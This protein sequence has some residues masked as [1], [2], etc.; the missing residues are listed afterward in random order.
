MGSGHLR[1]ETGALV[2]RIVV[3]SGRAVGVEWEQGGVARTATATAEV[4]LS[5]GAVN[6][7]QVLML[8]GIG[9]A[10]HLK[11]HGIAVAVDLPGVGENLQDHLAV[12]VVWRTTGTTSLHDH[13]TLGSLVRWQVLRS[14]PLTS[15]VAEAC[16]FVRSA[17]HLPAP[18]LQ[19]HVAPAAFVDNG[20]GEPPGPGFTVAP[21]LVAPA[22]SG[23]L[24]LRS[25]HPGWRPEIDAGYLT[26]DADLEALVVGTRLAREM[27]QDGPLQRWLDRELMPGRSTTSPDGLR[28]HV[29]ATSQTLYHPVGTCAMGVG[30]GSVVDL[31]CRVRG[32]DG[33]RVVDA[34]I[35][36]RV[37]RGNTNAPTIALAEKAAELILAG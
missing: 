10:E 37:P 30:D 2:T 5:G 11:E 31:E 20:L 32:V 3:E 15:T 28:E 21:V 14:G 17:D 4:L 13:E 36:P 25:A 35:M 24:R 6:S 29:R 18:D 23:R 7:P 12:P 9:P 34:S 33:L 1:V 19:Y 22:S 8:S 16:A 27:V 26:E